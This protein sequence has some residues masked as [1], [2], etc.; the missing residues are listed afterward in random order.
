M[1]MVV[2]T[3]LNSVTQH[4]LHNFW[5]GGEEDQKHMGSYET[6]VLENSILKIGALLAVG[7]GDAGAAIIAE[8]IRAEGDINPMM[9]GKRMVGLDEAFMIIGV[10]VRACL[11]KECVQMS[12]ENKIRRFG[13]LGRFWEGK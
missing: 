12:V 7:F 11:Y 9:P 10:Q 6:A 8:N 3:Y 1:W 5:D 4:L 2:H 13:D